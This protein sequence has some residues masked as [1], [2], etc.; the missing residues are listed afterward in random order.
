[1]T[2]Q[3]LTPDFLPSVNAQFVAYGPE[4]RVADPM[5]GEEPLTARPQVFVRYYAG[6]RIQE[7]VKGGR[8]GSSTVAVHFDPES[9][10]LREKITAYLDP[11]DPLVAYVEQQAAEGKEVHVGLETVRR[12]KTK[13]SR[14]TI[15]PLTP[16]HALR[17]AAAP[18]GAK[19]PDMMGKSGENISNRVAML[20]GRAARD[21]TSEPTEWKA[22]V[23]NKS[24]DLP[25]EGWKF[26][27]PGDSWEQYGAIVPSD[28]ATPR[29]RP[30]ALAAAPASGIDPD[31]LA[32]VIE[33]TLHKVL[34]ER[35]SNL[36]GRSTRVF[37]EG[38]AWT[39]RT[40]DGRINLGGTAVAAEA[41]THRWAH[42]HLII[43]RTLP[44]P[45]EV[46][47]LTGIVMDL[48]DRVQ[49]DSYG[50][51][52]HE[53]TPDRTAGSH[54]EAARWVE[55]VI[56]QQ[57]PFPNDSNDLSG[58]AT[59]VATAATAHL[60]EAGRRVG[61][62]LSQ[63]GKN[64]PAKTEAPAEE[65]S[66][67]QGPSKPVVKALLG[68]IKAAWNDMDAIKTTCANTQEKGLADLPLGVKS[69]EEDD[70]TLAYPAPEGVAP[71][72]AEDALRNRW[73][74]LDARTKS[75]PA[76]PEPA[77]GPAPEPETQAEP[78][79][80]Q[81]AQQPAADDPNR[82]YTQQVAQIIRSA[83]G[84]DTL[85]ALKAV[86]SEAKD[87]NLLAS[88]VSVLTDDA[89][90]DLRFGA[91][92]ENGYETRTIAQT[93]DYLRTRLSANAPAT[94]EAL[95]PQ[96]PT[97]APAA[98]NEPETEDNDEW[99]DDQNSD[100]SEAQKIADSIDR[101]TSTVAEIDAA[102]ADAQAGGVYEEKVTVDGRIGALRSYL[103]SARKRAEKMVE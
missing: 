22:L 97:L 76:T 12:G 28:T 14:E 57:H 21:I 10:G 77:A 42:E 102:I 94:E 26:Y 89:T 38:T 40:N 45:A 5:G 20:N 92:G 46:W 68:S 25:P 4:V 53:V 32:A 73:Q 96:E 67:P 52:N 39:P 99:S 50:R 7:V 43:D 47:K 103:T 16:I 60:T 33:K 55:W 35:E 66:T 70:P 30:G 24:G 83:H 85:D 100:V 18:D 13:T 87:A 56:D 41:F 34:D 79:A 6:I 15:S 95:A 44:D 101:N 84:A 1:M 3:P 93:L 64:T 59:E 23:N 58:W 63:R 48:A 72:T 11:E 61:E 81:P 29:P 98:A 2:Q 37:K 31:A 54:K 74:V 78:A 17:G 62:H 8:N 51:G 86:Y 88:T 65:P 49:V 80:E 19:G 69:L 27:A 82:G 90:G 75:A 9:V 91:N 71:T 36:P